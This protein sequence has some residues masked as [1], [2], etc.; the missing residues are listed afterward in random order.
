MT[1]T[2]YSIRYEISKGTNTSTMSDLRGGV[3]SVMMDKKVEGWRCGMP[4]SKG[5]Q[6]SS[7][8]PSRKK[9]PQKY[10]SSLKDWVEQQAQEILPVLLPGAVYETTLNVE[11]IRSPMR[12]DK[13]FKILYCGEEHVLHIE[14]E[15]GSDGDLPSRLLIYNA[16]LY[17][18]HKLPVITIVVYPFPVEE[19]VPPLCIKSDGKELLTF[20]FRTLPL[21]SLDA[22]RFVQEQRTCMYPI[23]PVMNGVRAKLIAQVMQELAERYRESETTLAQQFAWM[24]ILLDRTGTIDPVERELI[25]EELTMFDKLWDESPR[26][27]RTKRKAREEARE[28]AQKEAQQQVEQERLRLQQEFEKARQDQ[29][30]K[31]RR[32]ALVSV[33]RARFPKLTSFARQHVEQFDTPEALDLLIQQVAAAPDANTVRVLLNP[34]PEEV[35]E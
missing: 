26:V 33:T 6:G 23:L 19:A 35:H 32:S 17:R 12:A 22:E 8:Q 2:E 1:K 4:K 31:T 21:Y 10:D 11:A 9:K 20:H 25:E 16:V 27:Q 13:V 3:H 24:R 29:E 30:V 18:D 5:K 34:S 15:T 14:F 28:E 7:Q